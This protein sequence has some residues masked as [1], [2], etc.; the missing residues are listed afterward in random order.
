MLVK[1]VFKLLPPQTELK[2]LGT[3]TGAC[4]HLPLQPPRV[5]LQHHGLPV[6]WTLMGFHQ[7]HQVRVSFSTGERAEGFP[8]EAG[9]PAGSVGNLWGSWGLL[10]QS[11]CSVD[12]NQ[13]W[14]REMLLGQRLYIFSLL[15]YC[16][17]YPF[18]C[19][20]GPNS[21]TKIDFLVLQWP[22]VGTR[23]IIFLLNTT[24]RAVAHK[25]SSVHYNKVIPTFP[26][27]S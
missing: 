17:S 1:D 16:E 21:M 2:L 8:Q 4:D 22:C 15:C 14:S 5:Q 24:L 3:A 7:I 18:C 27:S 13:K 20:L 12:Q 19:T 23:G 26:S 6:T 10:H 9:G 11:C 25:L